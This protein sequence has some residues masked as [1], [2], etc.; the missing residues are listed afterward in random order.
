MATDLAPV[1]LPLRS[2]RRKRAQ[3]LQKFQHLLPAVLL[4]GSAMA[5]FR[6]DEGGAVRAIAIVQAVASVAF[7]ASVAH[8]VRAARRTPSGHGHPPHAI[9]WPDVFV[10]GIFFAE[11]LERWHRKGKIF[12]PP[13][14]SALALLALGL[15]HGRIFGAVERHRSLRIDE[16]GMSMGRR[17]FGTFK[18]SWGELQSIEFD[19]RYARIRRRDGRERR[20]DMNDV[21]DPA[22]VRRALEDAR[23]R[24]AQA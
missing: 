21:E 22:P 14:L 6:T 20:I 17:P 1:T 15:L 4:I 24:I 23:R 11:A 5:S 13:L 3:L 12:S 2:K 7:I 16:A 18:V 9:D 8:S 19:A 10:A